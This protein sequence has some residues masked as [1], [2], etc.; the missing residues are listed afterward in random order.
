MKFMRKYY[1]DVMGE[2]KNLTTELTKRNSNNETLMNGLKQINSMIN[3]ASNLRIGSHKSRV[4][5]LCRAA[6][7]SNNLHS[8]IFII[9]N[10][11]E[12]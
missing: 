10:G 7:K 12:F 11:R 1:T 8:L 9:E 3:K 5:N 2:N 4:T 6:I